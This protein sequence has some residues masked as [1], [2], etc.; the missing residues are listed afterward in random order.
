MTRETLVSLRGNA[1]HTSKRRPQNCIS[2]KTLHLWSISNLAATAGRQR[3]VVPGDD[4]DSPNHTYSTPINFRV[5][6]SCP[7]SDY[8]WSFHASLTVYTRVK[9][10]VLTVN[11]RVLLAHLIK[12]RPSR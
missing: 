10:L 3:K 5:F 6:E 2:H 12:M 11:T 7:I 4:S 8:F 1:N 9:S